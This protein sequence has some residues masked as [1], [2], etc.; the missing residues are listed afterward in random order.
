MCFPQVEQLPEQIPFAAVQTTAPYH[1]VGIPATLY[2]GSPLQ[3]EALAGQTLQTQPPY[4]ITPTLAT[5]LITEQ[6]YKTEIVQQ[7]IPL[8]LLFPYSR[9]LLEAR[10]L[11]Q[12][13]LHAVVS[14]MEPSA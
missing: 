3:M 12:I 9:Y 13:L 11:R 1:S 7:L 10:Y 4:I 6:L 8:H 5:L 14:T 2:D